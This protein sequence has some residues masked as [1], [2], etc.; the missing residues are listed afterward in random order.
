M[1]RR[2]RVLLSGFGVGLSWATMLLD[3]CS[4]NTED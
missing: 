1:A 3:S 4:T 2:R